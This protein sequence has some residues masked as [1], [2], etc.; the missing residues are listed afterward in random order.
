MNSSGLANYN[1]KDYLYIT[2][3]GFTTIKNQE[4]IC[5]SG[6]STNNKVYS[7]YEAYS[8]DDF[9]DAKDVS[10]TVVLGVNWVAENYTLT[11]DNLYKPVIVCH[12]IYCIMELDIGIYNIYNIF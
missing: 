4:W 5:L 2:K 1:N 11:Y 6:C 7:Q 8:S 9:C 12:C 3:R 10:C